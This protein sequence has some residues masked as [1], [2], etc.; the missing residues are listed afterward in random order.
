MTASEIAFARQ[1]D[2][3]L[4]A[5]YQRAVEPHRARIRELRRLIAVQMEHIDKK[6]RAVYRKRT[7]IAF[8]AASVE[9]PPER[10][11]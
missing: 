5:E 7:D 1:R 11:K 8:P 6:G 2:R 9:T 10:P 4:E 3:E